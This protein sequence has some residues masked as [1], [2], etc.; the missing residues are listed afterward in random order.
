MI[1]INKMQSNTNTWT[2]GRTV[3]LPK[4][5]LEPAHKFLVLVK[6]LS[7]FWINFYPHTFLVIILGYV[8]CRYS[9]YSDVT[10][11]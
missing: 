8:F 10:Y 2:Y 5:R 1:Y 3:R 9:K 11:F 4:L 6:F 7:T